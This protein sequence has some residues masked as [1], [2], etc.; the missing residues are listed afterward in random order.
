MAMEIITREDLEAFRIRL[1]ND[2]KVIILSQ[3][4]KGREPICES[5][6][7][8]DVRKILGCSVNKL[9]SLRIARKIRWKKIGGTL[10]YNK[11]DVRRLIE[12][13]F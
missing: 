4:E 13:G 5:Y 2:L 1:L 7:T 9:V 10:Y 8:K 11:D 12:E 6:R 3:S